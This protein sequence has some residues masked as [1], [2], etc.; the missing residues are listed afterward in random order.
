MA[1]KKIILITGASTPKVQARVAALYADE[2]ESRR[3]VRTRVDLS[4]TLASG[5]VALIETDAKMV[6]I[7]HDSLRAE[8]PDAEILVDNVVA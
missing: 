8:W 5:H 3:I 7:R 4:R 6:G 2:P 1:E